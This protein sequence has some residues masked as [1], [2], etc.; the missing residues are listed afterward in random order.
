MVP[1]IN[2]PLTGFRIRVLMSQKGYSVKDIQE[3]LGLA[4][5]QGIYKWLDGKTLPSIDNLVGLAAVLDVSI[6][7][8]L[9]I[10]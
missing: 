6:N 3:K 7:D 5:P 2:V 10:E 8:I 1:T 9:V 4:C